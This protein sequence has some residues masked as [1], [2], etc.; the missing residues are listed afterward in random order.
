M[1]IN[2]SNEI[3]K[4]Y[5]KILNGTSDDTNR[6]QVNFRRINLKIL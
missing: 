1:F 3:E 4:S 6:F 2:I 5:I